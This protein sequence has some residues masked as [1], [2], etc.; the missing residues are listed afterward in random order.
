MTRGMDRYATV[1]AYAAAMR[2]F[3]RV[4]VTVD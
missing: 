3:V 1:E 4:I 2:L